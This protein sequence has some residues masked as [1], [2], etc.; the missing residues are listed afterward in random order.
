MAMLSV[1]DRK[2]LLGVE[3]NSG[4]NGTVLQVYSKRLGNSVSWII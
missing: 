4:R 2:R 1:A 3:N